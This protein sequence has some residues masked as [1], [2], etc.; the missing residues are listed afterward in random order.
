M[1]EIKLLETLS[2]ILGDP[3][4]T[5]GMVKELEEKKDKNEFLKAFKDLLTPKK[6]HTEQKE[7]IL[8]ENIEVIKE[9]SQLP[10][11][12]EDPLPPLPEVPVDFI[13]AAARSIKATK[14]AETVRDYSVSKLELD[15][16]KKSIIDLHAFASQMSNMGGG[17]AGDVINLTH[18]TTTVSTSPYIIGRHDY[19][20]GVTV[21]PCTITLPDIAKNGRY[22]II[23]DEVGNCSSNPITVQGNVDNDTGGF[24]LAENNGGI[25]MIYHNNG[26]R[27]I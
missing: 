14:P 25:Q 17:G 21:T 9:N 2:N 15:A 12:N 11:I 3:V 26:W 7:F 20:V 4:D 13:T 16:I 27:I 19:Y 22:L 8:S 5:T 24:I 23:K 6:I 10:L 18:Q 1:D